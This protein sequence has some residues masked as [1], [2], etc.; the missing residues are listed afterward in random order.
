MMKDRAVRAQI[1]SESHWYFFN[2][3]FSKYVTH[4]TALFQREIF[5]LTEREDV[6]NFFIVAFRGS[7]KSTIV[8][9]SYPI[10]AILGKQQKKFILIVCQTKAQ[11]KQHMMNLR[12]ELE[13]NELLKNDLGPFQEETD[14]WGANSL[15]FSTHG[16]RIS[17]A[18]ADQSIRGVRHHQHRPDLIIGDDVE[19]M[20][21]TKTR[22]GRDKTYQ[23]LTSEIIPAGTKNTRVVIVGNLLHQDSLLMR[24]KK[25]IDEGRF[26]GIFRG[27]PLL[28]DK[29]ECIWPGMYPTKED[30]EEL[31]R[32]VG[33]ENAWQ[34]EYLLRIIPEDDQ[35]VYPEWIHH[36]DKLPDEGNLRATVMGVD[37]AI[38]E[39][40][41]ADYTAMVPALIHGWEKNFRVYILPNIVN[42]R[43]NFPETINLL[44]TYYKSLYGHRRP[45]ILIE[46]VGYQRSVIQQLHH[47]G[48]KVSGVQVNGDK[49]S[50]LMAVT[51]LI[52]SGKI[53]FPRHGAEAL[54]EQLIGFGVEK[55]DDM[56]DAF[57]IMAHRAIELDKRAP[58]ISI[59]GF[60]N[61]GST[62]WIK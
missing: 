48:Y 25:N 46:D 23:W 37:L 57:T 33:N 53:L 51:N 38:S 60:R 31:H 30:I 44:Q 45:E 35:V 4:P 36:Y 17:I 52:Q 62:Y 3:Y 21:S 24:I 49:R 54:I 8:T 12:H 50:R 55:H 6:K 7:G 39:R 5:D 32:S 16:A 9:T 13:N 18:S 14:E 41:T 59:L 20:A 2:F 26:S 27:Y 34:R 58:R 47:T 22:E 10:W 61:D 11:A 42:K 43:M 56:V 40:D 28:D 19:D 29:N 15:V 1:T